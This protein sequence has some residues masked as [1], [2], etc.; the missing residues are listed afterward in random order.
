ML[1]ELDEIMRTIKTYAA[2]EQVNN[3]PSQTKEINLKPQSGALANPISRKGDRT[4]RCLRDEP[5]SPVSKYDV[6]S[7][8]KGHY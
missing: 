3:K 1:S 7:G 5:V 2:G 6:T 8:S 4:H